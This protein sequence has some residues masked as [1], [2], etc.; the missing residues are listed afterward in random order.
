MDLQLE[1]FDFSIENCN[2]HFDDFRTQDLYTEQW[3]TDFVRRGSLVFDEFQ[4]G[5]NTGEKM[6]AKIR[7]KYDDSWVLKAIKFAMS[8]RRPIDNYLFAD[9]MNVSE[10]M[11][12]KARKE[13]KDFDDVF[14]N[15]ELVIAL[16]VNGQILDNTESWDK[17]IISKDSDGKSKATKERMRPT[18]QDLKLARESGMRK[19]HNAFEEQHQRETL[20]AIRARMQSGEIS[21]LEAI[22]ECEEEGLDVPAS[23]ARIETA[24]VLALKRSK[25]INAEEAYDT[26]MTYGLP[27]SKVLLMQALA[28][29]SIVPLEDSLEL[30][31]DMTDAEMIA[32]YMKFKG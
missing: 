17:T 4:M 9:H 18:Y 1:T 26:L 22:S 31:D 29:G 20:K 28:E 8:S 19:N 5:E 2:V 23:W 3:V 6:A 25:A 12:R 16:R 27:V 13:N 32:A 7:P 11:V 14:V 21:Y 15:A 24:R 30:S 10:G